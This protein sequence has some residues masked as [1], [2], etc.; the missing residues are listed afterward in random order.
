MVW[1]SLSNYQN[2]VCCRLLSYSHSFY[3]MNANSTPSPGT[4]PGEHPVLRTWK[5][6]IMYLQKEFTSSG[7]T[8][9]YRCTSVSR[10][11][12]NIIKTEAGSMWGCRQNKISSELTMASCRVC[13]TKWAPCIEKLLL[14]LESTRC[15]YKRP[16]FGS[17]HL[18][19]AAAHNCSELQF[20]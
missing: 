5:Y 17:Q 10:M 3:A 16:K 6:D 14:G 9:K 19:F 13:W 20:H 11:S 7:F 1:A 2:M 4:C 8:L 12:F 18:H 15:S